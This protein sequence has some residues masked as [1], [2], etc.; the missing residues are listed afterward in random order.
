M[1]D[2]TDEESYADYD[3]EDWECDCPTCRGEQDTFMNDI[4]RNR[5]PFGGTSE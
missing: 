4:Q 3:D 5:V 2:D 1:T